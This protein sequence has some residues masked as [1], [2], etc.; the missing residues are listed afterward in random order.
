M[1]YLRLEFVGPRSLY[2]V[3]SVDLVG[4]DA[5]HVVARRLDVLERK[6]AQMPHL[7]GVVLTLST[8][9]EPSLTP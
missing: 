1:T 4:D 2:L 7:A 8:P 6:V 9:E 5:E 3:A